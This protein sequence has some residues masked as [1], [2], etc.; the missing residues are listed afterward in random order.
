VSGPL[1]DALQRA[2]DRLEDTTQDP[3]DEAAGV[4]DV[5]GFIDVLEHAAAIAAEVEHEWTRA[6]ILAGVRVPDVP[7]Y[8]PLVQLLARAVAAPDEPVCI[9]NPVHRDDDPVCQ[10]RGGTR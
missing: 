5:N 7:A 1:S 10:W 6:A 9:C 3:A 4:V 2:A 8:P